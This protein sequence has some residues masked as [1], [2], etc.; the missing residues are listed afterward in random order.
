MF[1]LCKFTSAILF[2]VK[3]AAC[4]VKLCVRVVRW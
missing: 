4:L 3:Y 1:L 2:T